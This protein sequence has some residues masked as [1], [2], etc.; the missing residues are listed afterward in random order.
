MA[1]HLAQTIKSDVLASIDQC[2]L[3]GTALDTAGVYIRFK[4]ILNVWP[5]AHAAPL[6][7]IVAQVNKFLSS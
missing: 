4:R 7:F 1:F 5:T 2:S 6:P 3:D